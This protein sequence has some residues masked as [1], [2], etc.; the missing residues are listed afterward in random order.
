M[1]KRAFPSPTPRR[2]PSYSPRRHAVARD[3]EPDHIPVRNWPKRAEFALKGRRTKAQCRPAKQR[4]E[5][6]KKA[7]G[8]AKLSPKKL[9][10]RNYNVKDDP[11]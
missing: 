2:T 9:K 4:R 5:L 6:S 10:V 8:K 7:A 11:R 1:Q 3:L